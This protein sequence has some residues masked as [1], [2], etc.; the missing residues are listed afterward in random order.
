[1]SKISSVSYKMYALKHLTTFAQE[2][3]SIEAE[4]TAFLSA[5]TEACP[6]ELDGLLQRTPVDVRFTRQALQSAA[7]CGDLAKFAVL[8]KY[9]DIDRLSDAEV[10]R[11]ICSTQ[12]ADLFLKHSSDIKAAVRR[13]L[14]AHQHQYLV[15]FDNLLEHLLFK[16]DIETAFNL[17]HEHFL[18]SGATRVGLLK[19]YV[20]AMQLTSAA[21][22]SILHNN[23]FI[24]HCVRFQRHADFVG[25][26][27]ELT[28]LGDNINQRYFRKYAL[29]NVSMRCV[30]Y[31][32]KIV[33]IVGLGANFEHCKSVASLYVCH[34]DVLLVA[35][36]YVKFNRAARIIQRAFRRFRNAICTIQRE[37]RN[38]I[39][40]PSRAMCR[41]RLV[42]EFAELGEVYPA[43]L[44]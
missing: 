18:P 1:M 8:L 15:I 35:F 38:C 34:E 31:K 21:V 44:T 5:C 3:A 10:L 14:R 40:N 17:L 13:I 36:C 6:E 4:T 39:A 2:A 20:H 33:M 42:S 28:T 9:V 41:K 43:L 22:T 30:D 27:M 11:S 32:Q 19:Q 29:Q 26:V 25:Q 7:I 23:S 16:V 37:W 24:A 12:Q